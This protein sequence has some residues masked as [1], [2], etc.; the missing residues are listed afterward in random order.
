MAIVILTLV[1]VAV[2]SGAVAGVFL[3]VVISIRRA[4][5]AKRLAA[6]PR[7]HA[8]TATRQLLGVTTRGASAHAGHP[9]DDALP[10]PL[11]LRRDGG[12]RQFQVP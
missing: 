11:L 10:P 3:M 2:L 6:G 12:G 1:T 4:D 8:D 7:G 5:R 9:A